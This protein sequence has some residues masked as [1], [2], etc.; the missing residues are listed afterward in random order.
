MTCI[1]PPMTME[2]IIDSSNSVSFTLG[3]TYVCLIGEGNRSHMLL[4]WVNSSPYVY[5]CN[6]LCQWHLLSDHLQR[7]I[8]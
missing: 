7:L 2:C 3:R 5:K 4:P 1:L 8:E 6:S